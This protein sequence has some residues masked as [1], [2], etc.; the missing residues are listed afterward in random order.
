MQRWL[1]VCIQW[2]REQCF[3]SFGTEVLSVKVNLYRKGSGLFVSLI[4]SASWG[5]IVH[6]QCTCNCVT[7]VSRS[8]AGWR[9]C[10]RSWGTLVS[11]ALWGTRWTWRT[12]EQYLPEK[13]KSELI[14]QKLLSLSVSCLSLS[15]SY[16][17]SC[18]LCFLSLSRSRSLHFM[19]YTC[20]CLSSSWLCIFPMEKHAQPQQQ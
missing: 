16:C 4:F 2:W 6:V 15:L 19:A 18:C 1:L 8:R 20:S 10:A 17:P 11:F 3:K 5:C 14:I 13:R 12:R 7:F 9:N